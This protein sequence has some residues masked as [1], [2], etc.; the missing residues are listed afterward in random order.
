MSRSDPEGTRVAELWTLSERLASP[1]KWGQWGRLPALTETRD[2][3][4]LERLLFHPCAEGPAKPF[5]VL[6]EPLIDGTPEFSA[7]LESGL[8]MKLWGLLECV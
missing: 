7:N 5:S 8:N 1:P 2:R 6:E 3:H 4:Q